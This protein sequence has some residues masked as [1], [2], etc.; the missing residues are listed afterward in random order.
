MTAL[1]L[2]RALALDATVGIVVTDTA[3]DWPG[4]TIVYANSAFG[5]LVGR[6]LS[7]V[8][9]QTPRFM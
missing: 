5:Q 9:G 3:I 7:D 1:E 4:P 8:V 2:I 6:D